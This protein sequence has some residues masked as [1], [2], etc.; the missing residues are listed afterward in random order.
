MNMYENRFAWI[1][2]EYVITQQKAI[3]GISGITADKSGKTYRPQIEKFRLDG[4]IS[5]TDAEF[6]GLSLHY[7]HYI[8]AGAFK[9]SNFP[10]IIWLHGLGSGGADVSLP[11]SANKACHFAS[12]EV[13]SLFGG[14]YVL[15]PQSPSFWMDRGK[16]DSSGGK[17]GGLKSKYTRAVKYLIDTYVDNNPGID[18][19]RIYIGGC[20][21]GGFM[22]TVLM[23]EYPGYFAAAFPVCSA[24]LDSDITDTQLRSIRN[25]P[26]WFTHAASDNV[27]AAPRH[28]L[29]TYD[30]MVK[31]GAPSVYYS[32]PRD[33][34]DLSGRYT[35]NDGSPYMYSG[36]S[37]WIYVYNNT[38][39][40][41]IDGKDLSILNWL[42]S[43]RKP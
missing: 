33:V 16:T 8:P 27:V 13:Q 2:C 18:R 26:V 11:I 24:A 23:T 22:T 3:T 14:A 15:V 7:A 36:H 10:L 28:S 1:T 38:L 43:Q 37:V 25:L 6:G 4:K 30:R 21:N 34:H 31:L 42:A 17:T 19:R 5:Y 39:T 40:Q 41:N 9:G 32:Y 35:N 29:A 20:S 12:G